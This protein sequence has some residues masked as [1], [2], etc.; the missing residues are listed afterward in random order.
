[1]KNKVLLI[2]VIGLLS[3]FLVT[4]V[5]AETNAADTQAQIDGLQLQVNSLLSSLTLLQQ[6]IN[7]LTLIQGPKGDKGEQGIQG[8]QGVSGINGIN[9]ARGLQG[10][11]G[12]NGINGKDGTN[13]KNGLQGIQGVSGINGTN[14]K[15]GIQG[16]Q[17]IPGIQGVSGINGIDGTN[18]TVD[19]TPINNKLAY[20]DSVV[21]SLFKF[22]PS[23]STYYHVQPIAK[24]D[25]SQ[26]KIGISCFNNN[27]KYQTFMECQSG[28]GTKTSCDAG[29]CQKKSGVLTIKCLSGCDIATN[30]CK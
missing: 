21:N 23:F 12:M 5:L 7:N 11:N 20:F 4:S 16:I 6:Q 10:F 30:L 19:L 14:G 17:G 25:C 9:G 27:S 22:L 15:N 1:M 24:E 29:Y 28:H 13:G 3:L 2:S 8:I 26:N 18:A